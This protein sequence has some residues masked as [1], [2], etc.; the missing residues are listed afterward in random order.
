MLSIK[1]WSSGDRPREKLLEKG[2][3]ALSDSE[4]LALLIGSGTQ[5]ET[6]VELSK[7]V[8][9][10]AHSDLNILGRFSLS[11]FLNHRGIGTAKAV[12]IMAAFELGRRRQVADIIPG[13]SIGSSREAVRMFQSKMCD[14]HYEEFWVLL[15]NRANKMINLCKVSQGGVS[16]TVIDNRLILRKA[17]ECLASG[18]IL[19]HNHPSGNVQPSESDVSITKKL[20][21]AAL[22]ID[23]NVLDHLIIAPGNSFSFADEGI[24]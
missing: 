24:L 7:K 2:V 1:Q 6:A 21:M 13:S 15:L 9:L 18:I 14:L 19:C 10:S 22:L 8:L 20:K 11:E 16:A 12:C 23:I 4:L 5:R 3:A 17:L